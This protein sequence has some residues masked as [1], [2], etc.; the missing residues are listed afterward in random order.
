MEISVR[1]GSKHRIPAAITRLP[2]GKDCNY[3]RVGKSQRFSEVPQQTSPVDVFRRRSMAQYKAVIE[4]YPCGKFKRL[5]ELDT[6]LL[7]A[8]GP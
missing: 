1:I 3:G 6:V 5:I 2:A 8:E 4:G 7:E